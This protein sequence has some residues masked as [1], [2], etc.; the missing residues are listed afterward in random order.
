MM[1]RRILLLALVCASCAQ[2]PRPSPEGDVAPIPQSCQ[3]MR[4]RGGTC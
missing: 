4:A 1:A 3:E 2:V